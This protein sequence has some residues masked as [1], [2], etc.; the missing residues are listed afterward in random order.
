MMIFPI[1]EL[2]DE[3]H[4]YD[5]LLKLLH[6]VDLHCPNGRSLLLSKLP[7]TETDQK[8]RRKFL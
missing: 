3:Q 5:Y 2:L 4:C 8:A 1:E 7:M 6:S